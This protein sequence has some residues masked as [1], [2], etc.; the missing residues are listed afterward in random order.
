MSQD[1]P[2]HLLTFG[3][4][5]SSFTSGYWRSNLNNGDIRLSSNNGKNKS[6]EIGFILCKTWKPRN[7]P[8]SCLYYKNVFENTYRNSWEIAHS[9]RL[10]LKVPV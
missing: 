4:R 2:M 3:N 6:Y 7:L 1:P 8:D 9:I 5:S 10:S